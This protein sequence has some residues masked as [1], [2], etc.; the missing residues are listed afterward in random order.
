[1]QQFI[2]TDK[3]IAFVSPSDTEATFEFEDVGRT[4]RPAIDDFARAI[5]E[6]REP[7]ITGEDA[8]G[9]QELVAAITLSG[10]RAEQVRLPVDRAEYDALLTELRWAGKLPR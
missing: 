4:H 1:M 3:T 5:I 9:A 6:D 10:C 7:A 2:D 8:L